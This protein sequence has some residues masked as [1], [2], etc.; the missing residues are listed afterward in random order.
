MV[1]IYSAIS[2]LYLHSIARSWRRHP[3][4]APGHRR[5]FAFQSCL[6][7]EPGYHRHLEALEERPACRYTLMGFQKKIINN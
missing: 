2:S 7:L 1:Y 6:L 4:V 3:L 5:S